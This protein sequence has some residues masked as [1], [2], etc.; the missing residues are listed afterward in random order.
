MNRIYFFTGTGNSLHIAEEIGNALSDCE[1]VAIQKGTPTDIP[2]G[3]ERI[4]FV[5]P[6]YGWGLPNMVAD[7]ISKAKLSNQGNTYLFAVATCL[8]IAGNAIPQANTLLN[9]KGCHLNY[10][11]KIKMFG[12]SVTNYNM[13]SKVDEITKKTDK[14]AVSVIRDIVNKEVRRIPPIN[15]LLYRTYLKFIR[16]VHTIDEEFSV[17]DDCTSCGICK[18][19]CP[20]KNITLVDGKPVFHHQCERCL[21]CIQH[22]PKHAI[23]YRDK[24]QKRRRYT[25]PQVRYKKIIK[26]YKD[27]D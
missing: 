2:A 9:E 4:G 20:A 26:Y 21:A 7:F 16:E 22:C 6:T 14:R 18:S 13:N 1:I 5:F 3:Y 8:G 27:A 25:H 19:V 24:T 10:G 17:N 11:A 23:N 12:N 15:Q